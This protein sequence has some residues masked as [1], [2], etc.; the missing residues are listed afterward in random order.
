MSAE[1]TDWLRANALPLSSLTPGSPTDDLQPLAETLREVRVVGLGEATHGTREFFQLKH[2]ILEFLVRE[3]GYSV[4]A[5]EASASAGQAVDAYVRHSIG[6]AEKVLTGLGFWIWRTREVLSVIEWMREY[7][8]KRAEDEHVRFVGIDPQQCGDSIAVLDA[9]LHER[10]PERV[11]GLHTTLGVLGRAHP[12][13]Y[14]DPRRRLVHAAEE[15]VDFL[16]DDAPDAAEA[17]RHARIL[18]QAA[19]LVT[20]KRLHEDPEQTVY[21]VRDRYM[22]DWVGELLDVPSTKVALWAHNGHIAKSWYG[23]GPSPLGQH[24]HERYGDVYYALGLLFGQGAFRAGRT[25]LGPWP[26]S[27][28]RHPKRNSIGMASPT[29]TEGQLA[30]AT[31]GNHLI[32]LRSG[33]DAPTAVRQWLHS[34]SAMRNFGAQVPRWTYH[35]HRSPTILAQEYDGLAYIATS[36]CSRPLPAPETRS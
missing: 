18:A 36:T 5:M 32:D 12:G 33:A 15:L 28:L 17:I 13:Q 19:D 25:H 8:R 31:A 30:A 29:T 26:G 6:D 2:R 1:V 35:L 7:N 4:L 10:A 21:A 16:C 11:A 22:A 24:L 34:T 23:S 20:R 14:P 3:M 9:F 27:R